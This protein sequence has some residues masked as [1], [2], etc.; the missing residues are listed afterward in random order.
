MA[1]SDAQHV[2]HLLV[3]LRDGDRTAFDNLLPLVYGELHRIATRQMK[4]QAPGHTLQATALINEAYLRLVTADGAAHWNNR[5]HF[6]S[7]AATAMRH[8]LVDYARARRSAKRGGG[9]R[10]VTLDEELVAANERFEDLLALDEAMRALE[11]LNA[12]QCRVV[13]MRHF[14]GLS[15]EETAAM[16]DV[17]PETVMRDWRAAKAWL[18]AELVRG[19]LS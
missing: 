5:V 11:T 8:V 2:T 18:Y 12:R 7:V 15:I 4:R 1:P 14:A 13:E 17:S 10:A 9:E 19:E 16:L 3:R 6:Y